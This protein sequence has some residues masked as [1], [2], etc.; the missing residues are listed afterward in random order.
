MVGERAIRKGLDRGGGGW[1]EEGET[2]IHPYL[3]CRSPG[4]DSLDINTPTSI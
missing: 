4:C 2:N 3:S 1:K